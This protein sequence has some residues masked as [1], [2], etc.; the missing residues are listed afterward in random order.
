MTEEPAGAVCWPVHDV[1]CMR[2]ALRALGF[3]TSVTHPHPMLLH[4]AELLEEYLE[5]NT[6]NLSASK[7]HTKTVK[8]FVG[9][10]VGLGWCML[11]DSYHSLLVVDT[12]STLGVNL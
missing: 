3:D 8:Y 2:R 10:A 5:R 6:R 9:R 4:F 7:S 12:A 11:N 1:T